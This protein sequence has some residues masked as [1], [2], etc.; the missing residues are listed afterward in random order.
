MSILDPK[1]NLIRG[2]AWTIGTRWGI[3]GL[4]FIST[5]VMARL[6]L[7]ED[8]GLVAMGMLVVGLIQTFVDFG[9]STALLRKADV[10]T[11]EIDSAWTLSIIQGLGIG[12]LLMM[13][14]PFAVA[15]FRETRLTFVLWSLAASV[16]FVVHCSK[17]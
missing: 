9:P 10:T 8:Y 3:K 2:A 5:I 17:K 1:R 6:L 12:L 4:G 15:Y 7:P 13:T 11:D 16:I 14:T